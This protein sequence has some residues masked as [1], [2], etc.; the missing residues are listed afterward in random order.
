M[1]AMLNAVVQPLHEAAAVLGMMARR[2]LTTRMTGHYVGDFTT[3]MAAINTTLEEMT[4]TTAQNA[5]HAQDARTLSE[6]ACLASTQATESMQ[7]LS[8]S[9]EKIKASGL[10]IFGPL[11]ARC[12]RSCGVAEPADVMKHLAA[13]Y[14]V[15]EGKGV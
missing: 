12:S 14:E 5:A 9:I 8:A 6:T 2:D 7:Q 3:L 11:K 4:A 13:S 10:L 15:S 1:N